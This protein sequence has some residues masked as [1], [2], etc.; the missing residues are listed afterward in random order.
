MKQYQRVCPQWEYNWYMQQRRQKSIPR[1]AGRLGRETDNKHKQTR[2]AASF[3]IVRL[4][5]IEIALLFGLL[6]FSG[7][8][9]LI[10]STVQQHAVDGEVV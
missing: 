9:L 8:L 5:W 1:L 4:Q 6:L 7:A 2:L 10:G 3:L